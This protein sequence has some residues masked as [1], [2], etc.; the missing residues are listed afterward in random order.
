MVRV[1]PPVSE[2]ERPL[3]VTSPFSSILTVPPWLVVPLPVSVL[4]VSVPDQLS[5]VAVVVRLKLPSVP[6]ALS[7]AVPVMLTV[8]VWDVAPLLS[9]AET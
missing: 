3:A 9:A 4:V 1:P 6:F 5:P 7:L 2:L 8:P